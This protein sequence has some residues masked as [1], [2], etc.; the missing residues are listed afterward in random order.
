MIPRSPGPKPRVSGPDWPEPGL[1]VA[2]IRPHGGPGLA[3]RPAQKQTVRRG[4]A[5]RPGAAF[6]R[7]P[8]PG[9]RPPQPTATGT[10]GTGR[11]RRVLGGGALLPRDPS[12]H[13]SHNSVSGCVVILAGVHLR[14]PLLTSSGAAAPRSRGPR[15]RPAPLPASRPPLSRRVRAQRVLGFP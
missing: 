8:R 5:P 15:T 10:E 1:R 7:C 2:R 12:G 13:R 6:V 3:H 9:P 11:E 14:S 4:A